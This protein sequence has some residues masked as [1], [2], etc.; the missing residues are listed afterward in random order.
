MWRSKAIYT[1]RSRRLLCLPHESWPTVL[2]NKTAHL[3]LSPTES[4]SSNSCYRPLGDIAP[5]NLA[6]IRRAARNSC[7]GH[8]LPIARLE[9]TKCFKNTPF[10]LY[11]IPQLIVVNGSVTNLNITD[12]TH[13]I[14]QNQINTIFTRYKHGWNFNYPK[15]TIKCK[16]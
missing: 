8:M 1:W 11:R 12:C 9:P 7:V 10:C 14:E 15:W 6:V 3:I 16:H 4:A 2:T 5:C 13:I